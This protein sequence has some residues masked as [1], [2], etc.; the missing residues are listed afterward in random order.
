MGHQSPF[1]PSPIP[2]GGL[3]PT[4]NPVRMT[5]SPSLLSPMAAAGQAAR[6]PSPAE[7]ATHTQKILQQA[8]IK[9][10]LEVQR[11]KFMAKESR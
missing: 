5:P 3:T 7:L 6:I 9:K 10:Q 2:P 11:E 8:L 1:A 4:K